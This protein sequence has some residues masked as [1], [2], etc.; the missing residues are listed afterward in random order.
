L[1]SAASSA[2]DSAFIS[3]GYTIKIW[4]LTDEYE[5]KENQQKEQFKRTQVRLFKHDLELAVCGRALVDVFYLA[6]FL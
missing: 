2:D 5:T 1:A 3:H 6:I 4:E